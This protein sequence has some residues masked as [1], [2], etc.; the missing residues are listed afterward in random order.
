MSIPERSNESTRPY[1]AMSD[2]ALERMN[3]T[4]ER[5]DAAWQAAISGSGPR[6]QIEDFLI[7][8]PQL[9]KPQL[10]GELIAVDI[11][12]RQRVAES[13]SESEYE[14]RFHEHVEIVR[15]AFSEQATPAIHFGKYTVRRRLGAGGQAEVYLVDH[16]IL[17]QELVLKI[18]LRSG[19]LAA[20]TQRE[21]LIREGTLLTKVSHPNLMR[22]Y[23]LDFHEDRPFLVLEFVK[24]RTLTQY[25]KEERP[26]GRCVASLIA[27]VARTVAHIHTHGVV[28][29]DIKPENILVDTAGKPYLMD[30]GMAI[31]RNAWTAESQLIGGSSCWT[32]PEQA[33]KIFSPQIIQSPNQL[34]HRCDIFSLGAV[35]Y[36][37]LCG[38]PPFKNLAHAKSGDFDRLKLGS[39]R[40]PR[41]L[42]AICL[43]AMAVNPDD[44]YLQASAFASD[45][46]AYVRRPRIAAITAGVAILC[47][48]FALM[49]HF[50]SDNNNSV[51]PDT[52]PTLDLYD[53]GQDGVI[54]PIDHNH[55]AV[56][57]HS[58]LRLNFGSDK[59]AFRYLLTLSG[60]G[61]S[62]IYREA[63]LAQHNYGWSIEGPLPTETLILLT[64][65]KPLSSGQLH[66]LSSQI[67]I[68]RLD[69]ILPL[70]YQILWDN[71]SWR[72][73]KPDGARGPKV[74]EAVWAD[75]LLNELQKIDTVVFSGRTL[76]LK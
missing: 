52:R 50:Q 14:R 23:D 15:K 76:T 68:L 71:K 64:G 10:L 61:H 38:E 47:L 5:F 69:P 33:S 22:V 16:P 75:K 12:F 11:E 17:D 29:Y 8:A 30:F 43:R 9:E 72:I 36:D 21:Q 2:S 56:P 19:K 59:S 54:R 27:R 45:L 57:L 55:G 63:D 1:Q 13:P 41:R 74:V 37:V 53:V 48:V 18:P 28:H 32:A 20:H 35:L 42:R 58:T 49:W 24:G 46:E 6:P 40:V 31:L 62:V 66:R 34:D 67:D 70:G 39:A 26:S 25:V 3:E 7:D 51:P 73:E 60:D 4:C 65:T 44:R